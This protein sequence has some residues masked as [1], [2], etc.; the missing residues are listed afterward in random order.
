MNQKQKDYARDRINQT[1]VARKEQIKRKYTRQAIVLDVKDKIDLV[2]SGK[3]R[4]KT[5][6]VI[7][8]LKQYCNP[9]DWYDFSKHESEK[10]VDSKK[11][12]EKLTSLRALRTKAV[13]SIMLGDAQEA[14]QIIQEFEKECNGDV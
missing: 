5:K 11:I 7:K 12:E 14:L 3:V 4:L 6:D 9:A 2:C 8:T 1:F 13:D 10:Q